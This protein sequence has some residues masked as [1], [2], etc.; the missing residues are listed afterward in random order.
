[1][2]ATNYNQQTT[3]R[4]FEFISTMIKSIYLCNRFLSDT[5]DTRLYL[6]QWRIFCFAENKL[7][8]IHIIP[9]FILDVTLKSLQARK[10]S[11]MRKTKTFVFNAILLYHCF[12]WILLSHLWQIF[13]LS[14][15]PACRKWIRF[16]NNVLATE[17]MQIFVEV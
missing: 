2:C 17:T 5:C 6:R 15:K 9:L 8:T 13:T 1:M 3:Y 12:S 14:C 11:Y 10:K 16:S 7:P 4:I